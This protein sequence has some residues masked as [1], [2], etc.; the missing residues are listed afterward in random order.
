[1]Q[2][3]HD[4]TNYYLHCGPVEEAFHSESRTTYATPI[5]SKSALR[6]GCPPVIHHNL[7]T[8]CDI[9]L[10]GEVP[11]MACLEFIS[12]RRRTWNCDMQWLPPIVTK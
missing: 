3:A 11:K 7:S 10:G 5:V 12:M 2:S 9:A 6:L 4:S 1:M 8:V